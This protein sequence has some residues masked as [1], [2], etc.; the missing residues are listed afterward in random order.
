MADPLRVL[1]VEDDESNAR[2]VVDELSRG[3]Y[4]PRPRRV[5]SAGE[6]DAA[7]QESWDLVICDYRVP[8]LTPSR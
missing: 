5:A 4:A 7:L 3:G 2:L 8:S 6:V 1:L